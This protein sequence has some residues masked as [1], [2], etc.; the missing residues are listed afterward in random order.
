MSIPRTIL[1]KL[2]GLSHMARSVLLVA[3]AVADED[4][5]A[6][7]LHRR[8]VACGQSQKEIQKSIVEL[9]TAGLVYA[10]R[11]G[12][13]GPWV[14]TLLDWPPEKISGVVPRACGNVPATRLAQGRVAPSG[15]A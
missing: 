2:A 12:E 5:E 6:L 8:S 10:R 4:G 15:R 14:V 11:N 3:Y 7:G 9:T 13:R 1:P